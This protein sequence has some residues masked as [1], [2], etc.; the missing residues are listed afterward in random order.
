M[1]SKG[2]YTCIFGGGA[3]RGIT[4]I[5]AIKALKELD[6]KIDTF[7]GSSVGS[8]VAA[9]LALGFETNEIKELFMRVNF[10][11]FRDIHFGINKDF[12]L[13]KGNIFTKW[14]RKAIEK[15]YYGTLYREDENPPVTFKDLKNNLIILTTDL[16]KFKPYE[17]SNFKTPDFEIASAIRIS[18]SM[19]GL[20]TPVETDNKKL[21]D[22]DLLKG[23]PLWKLSKNL[24]IGK[25]RVLEFRLEGEHFS[26]N[27]N[28]FEFLNSIYSCMTSISTD[29]IIDTYGKNDRYDYI[30]IITGDIIIIDFNIP[31]KIR[32]KLIDIGYEY[33]IKYLTK[34][35][36]IKKKEIIK[37]YS[38]LENY[39]LKIIKMLELNNAAD[40]EGYLKEMFLYISEIYEHI[41]P[42]IHE[43]IKLLK[44][45]LTSAVLKIGWFNR[46]KY[47]NK[48]EY[49]SAAKNVY[50]NINEKKIELENYV[51]AGEEK[52]QKR[53]ADGAEAIHS[54]PNGN[55]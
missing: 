6:I 1:T 47:T 24:N 35:S 29:F 5:G 41:D 18:C 25:N 48:Y 37:Y 16:N 20:M 33:T 50:R 40:T 22:G 49:L 36:M 39:L 44:N 26:G 3:I 19:P 10:E 54:C 9:F 15:K 42:K 46:L 27:G 14:V 28:T 13:S 32:N 34:D 17:F 53:E 23:V 8:I 7:A 12:A 51:N 11:L 30:K 45:T 43:D 31:E 21:V 2:T 4:Y 55:A 38:K 52:S